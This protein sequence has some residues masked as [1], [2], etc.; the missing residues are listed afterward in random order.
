MDSEERAVGSAR[1]VDSGSAEG[2]EAGKETPPIC[3]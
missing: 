3:R 1:E 2:G